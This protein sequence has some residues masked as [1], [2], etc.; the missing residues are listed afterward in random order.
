MKNKK[1]VALSTFLTFLFSLGAMFSLSSCSKKPGN[2][3]AASVKMEGQSANW[4]VVVAALKK[5]ATQPP[6]FGPTQPGKKYDVLEVTLDIEYRGPNAEVSSPAPT[7]FDDKGTTF[8]CVL[9]SI[10]LPKGSE[11]DFDSPEVK[12]LNAVM[13][14]LS[15]VSNDVPKRRL[16]KTGEKFSA[17]ISFEDPKQYTNLKL[18]FADVPPIPLKVPADEKGPN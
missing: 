8:K 7:L 12:E 17:T 2:T 16:V 3:M 9:V 14:W 13:A 11:K 10:E 4:K 18:T 6:A 15:P 1:R 5:T